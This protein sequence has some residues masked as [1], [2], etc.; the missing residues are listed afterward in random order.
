MRRDQQSERGSKKGRR[1]RGNYRQID[2]SDGQRGSQR[3]GEVGD[4]EEEEED[5]TEG[6]ETGDRIKGM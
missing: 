6:R 4:E 2:A 5:A 1:E 3:Q